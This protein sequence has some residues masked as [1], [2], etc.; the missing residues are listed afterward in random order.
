PQGAIPSK[1]SSTQPRAAP[2]RTAATSSVERRKPRAIADGSADG[3]CCGLTSDEW[4]A[5]MWPSCSPRRLSLAESAASSPGGRSRSP[6]PC[7]SSAML[8]TPAPVLVGSRQFRPQNR[9]DHTDWVYASQ[10]LP[11]AVNV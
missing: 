1:R 4:S 6:F 5:W 9:A 3:G 8:S 7:A 10:E 2:T 11:L